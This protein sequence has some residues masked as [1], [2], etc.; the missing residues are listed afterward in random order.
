MIN[1]KAILI[2]ELYLITPTYVFLS[3]KKHPTC[4]IYFENN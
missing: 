1:I 3:K 4:N 2:L